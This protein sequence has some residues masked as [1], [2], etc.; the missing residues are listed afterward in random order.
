[1]W[2]KKYEAQITLE[3]TNYNPGE[4]VNGFVNLIVHKQS[5]ITKIDMSF[6][7][8][9]FV[10]MVK[11]ESESYERYNSKT[12]QEETR[13]RQITVPYTENRV[14][15]DFTNTLWVNSNGQPINPGQYQFPFS[16][17]LGTS[18][19]ASF[20]HK[21]KVKSEPC[22][23][24][25]FYEIAIDVGGLG[26]LSRESFENLVRKEI[27]VVQVNDGLT[28]NRRIES[29][30]K[31][32][33][34]CKQ[35]GEVKLVAFFEKDKY[36]IGSKAFIIFEIDNSTSQMNIHSVNAQ[37]EQHYRFKAESA[38]ENK[39]DILQK[40]KFPGI[41]A[42]SKLTGNRAQ[43]AEIM[44]KGDEVAKI[45]IKP[46]TSS[47]LINCFHYLNVELVLDATCYCGKN[48]SATLQIPIY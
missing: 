12:Q 36:C 37:L 44:I 30:S 1:M 43:R 19:P 18:I 3:K 20:N 47:R 42:G 26:F 6:R 4:Q 28:Q 29:V 24:C 23:A 45:D 39:K 46:S 16:F 17:T 10:N 27:Q 35:Y 34:C 25:I 14:F 41:A 21:W 7:G 32:Q 38:N 33:H 15:Y 5:N 31:V 8:E 11:T 9:E 13:T 2:G 40:I 22:D 48:P